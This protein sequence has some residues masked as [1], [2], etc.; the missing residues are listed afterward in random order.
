M[1][2]IGDHFGRL[3]I[4]E[5][6]EIKTKETGKLY[7][8]CSCSCGNP[9]LVSVRSEYLG[10]GTN[11]CG[12]LRKETTRKLGKTNTQVRKQ[13]KYDLVSHEYGVG[14]TEKGYSFLFDL[15]DYDKIKERYWEVA[16]NKLGYPYLK[17]CINNKQYTMSNFIM[18]GINKEDKTIYDHINQNSLDN[19]KENLRIATTSQNGMNVKKRKNNTSGTIGVCQEKKTGKWKA[20][21]KVNKK[22]V[23]LGT[24]VSKEDAIIARLKAEKKYYGEFAPQKDLFE[25]YG[26]K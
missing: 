13:N 7:W 6:D 24:F 19:R 23:H 1:K 25:Q 4:V 11:S 20:T 17:T 22:K 26:V 18:K 10:K 9:K 16:L 21:I 5:K 15:E 8:L 14:Y 12:C 2:K 3:T